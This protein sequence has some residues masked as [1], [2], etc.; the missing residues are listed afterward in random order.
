[1]FQSLKK[2]E[3]IMKFFSKSYQT[4]I[5]LCSCLLVFLSVGL[6]SNAFSIYF[7][8]IMEEHHFNNTQV[9]LL[10]SMRNITALFCMFFAE[11]YYARFDLKKGIFLSL[12]CAVLAFLIYS[13]TSSPLTY[14]IASSISGICYS[15]GGMIP[16]SL[17]IRRWFSQHADSAL[18]LM[19]SGSGI[20]S[21]LGPVIITKLVQ[22]FGLSKTFFMEAMLIAAST[23]FLMCFVRNQ[24]EETMPHSQKETI[25]TD[26]QMNSNTDSVPHL[27]RTEQM[28]VSISLLFIGAIGITAFS[29]LSLLY[30]SNGHSVE[31]M[32][33]ALSFLGFMLIIGKLSFGV[34][35][36]R[37][38]HSFALLLFSILLAAGQIL[39][40]LAPIAGQ[41]FILFTFALLG[42]GCAI[43]GAAI[44]I[45]TKDFSSAQSYAKTLKNYQLIYT[46]GGLL[47]STIPGILADITGSY[48]SS[49][50]L[51]SV[52]AVGIL[53]LLV[54]VHRKY[55]RT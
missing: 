35:A 51:F 48:L 41:P 13:F 42:L 27:T 49:Y 50:L 7:P 25:R 54:P 21:I 1:M 16:A 37:F 26:R 40:C 19:A 22:T 4:I 39:C 8:F 34:I 14:A 30:V 5:C 2:E 29:G 9:S 17:L 31:A 53:V 24:P 3:Y 36:D 45:L 12:C 46:L 38:G 20:A 23:V 18:G 43:P 32:S 52:C 28:L 11:R 55:A 47:T 15:L 44:P 6:L 33:F 10:N